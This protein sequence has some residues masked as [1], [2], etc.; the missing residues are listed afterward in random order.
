MEGKTLVKVAK[1]CC[2]LDKHFT[3]TDIDLIFAKV[4]TK[5]AKKITFQQ[6]T[7]ALELI[8]AKKGIS[9][10]ELE[11]RILSVGGPVFTGTK[12]EKVKWHDDKSTYTGVYA[13]G[14]P[15]IIDAGKT[16]IR[17]ISELC[18]RSDADVRGVK[19]LE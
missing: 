9:T 18:D 3:T 8:A 19:K 14:G 5:G 12:T 7:S 10:E 11:S 13:K 4:K 17:D 2:L 15:S 1:D 16:M 6:F